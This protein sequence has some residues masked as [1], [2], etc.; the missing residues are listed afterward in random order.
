MNWDVHAGAPS[1]VTDPP[2]HEIER[3]PSRFEIFKDYV[4]NI[5]QW[6]AAARGTAAQTGAAA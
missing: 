1:F 5:A 3:D 4:R 6:L 2:G